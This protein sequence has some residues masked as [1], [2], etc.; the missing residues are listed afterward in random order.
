MVKQ[1]AMQFLK[2]HKCFRDLVIKLKN[3][4]NMEN[5]R[6]MSIVDTM[7]EMWLAALIQGIRPI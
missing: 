2:P 5:M 6:Y 7:D 1:T 4:I 3:M